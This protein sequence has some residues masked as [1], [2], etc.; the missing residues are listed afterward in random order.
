MREWL[1]RINNGIKNFPM[2]RSVWF[3]NLDCMGGNIQYLQDDIRQSE[4][5]QEQTNLQREKQSA[6]NMRSSQKMSIEQ[7]KIQ[8]QK[9][10]AE[11]QFQIAR[12]NKNQYDKKSDDKKKK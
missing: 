1:R 12:E 7:Q 9:D 3:A 6:E 11:K 10:I 5:Y 8:A 4:Q 2:L